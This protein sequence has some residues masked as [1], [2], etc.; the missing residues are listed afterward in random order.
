MATCCARSCAGILRNPLFAVAAGHGAGDLASERHRG[1]PHRRLLRRIGHRRGTSGLLAVLGADV[2]SALVVRLLSF[3]LSLLVPICLVAGTMLFMATE[4]RSLLQLG[5][6]LIG[7]GLLIL[8]LRLIGE[9][10]EPLR[11]SRILPDVVGYLSGDP[12][13]A[14]LLAAVMTWLFHS[15]VAAIL[16]VVALAARGILPL[17][18]GVVLVLGANVGGGIIA[19]ML[20]RAATPMAR[21]VPLGNLIMR[22]LGAV[23]ALSPWSCSIRRCGCSARPRP[24]S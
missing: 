15:S 21:I 19:V 22:A 4:R 20:S 3:D 8:S 10:S 2:G 14:F 12:V 9:A 16:L 18:L 23:L 13:T 1:R 24:I 17:E 11:D 5:R 6:I 7:V